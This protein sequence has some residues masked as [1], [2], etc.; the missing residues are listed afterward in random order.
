[1]FPVNEYG[2]AFAKQYRAEQIS[3]ADGHRLARRTLA[4][5][6][7]RP[8]GRAHGLFGWLHAHPRLR[9]SHQ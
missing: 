7:A 1:M 8:R 5:R 2:V 6:P 9:H 3:A 4:E